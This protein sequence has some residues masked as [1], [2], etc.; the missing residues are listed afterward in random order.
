MKTVRHVLL[1]GDLA[2]TDHFHVGD[3]AMLECNL[4]ML[5]RLLPEAC[6]SLMSRDPL[7]SA[8]LYDAQAVPRLGFAEIS[9]D[10][11][12]ELQ[13][14]DCWLALVERQPGQLPEALQA[15]LQADL[16]VISGGGNLSSSWP[17]YILERLALVRLA[18]Q[19]GVPL[20]LLGQ[21]LG[22]QLSLVDRELVAEILGA[23]AWI[24]LREASSVALAL[25]LGAPL[26]RID[27]QLDDAMA[28]LPR[29]STLLE[30]AWPEP[31]SQG[32]LIALTLHPLFAG[33]ERDLWLDCVATELDKVVAELGARF[34][35]IPHVCDRQNGCDVGDRAIGLALAA[36]LQQPAAMRVLE[37]QGSGE[38]AWL[39]QQADL[40]VSSRYHPLVF[41]LARQRPCLG[42]PTD[43]YTLVKLQGALSHAG[44]EED[45]LIIRDKRW[46][47]LAQRIVA[48]CR[49]TG[50]APADRCW[51]SRLEAHGQGRE[52]RLG[53]W[54]AKQQQGL[55]LP[56]VASGNTELVLALARLL[57]EP[58][59]ARLALAREAEWRDAVEHW[60]ASAQT[61]EAY[62]LDLVATLQR[63]TSERAGL[64]E[65][66]ESSTR[67]AELAEQYAQNLET[68][69]QAEA[70]LVGSYAL[71]RET[72]ER[73]GLLEALE[74]S[75][76]RAELAE[77]YAQSLE[78]A[79]QT[80]AAQYA[81][82][83]QLERNAR[84]AAN[85]S[86]IR[87]RRLMRRLSRGPR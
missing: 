28:L 75:T 25:G 33:A 58:G 32:P 15:L 8:G 52:Q 16:L 42:L 30:S 39:T 24:G 7:M 12:V 84:A 11:Q 78:T 77:Q 71:Q 27:Y 45:L 40:V 9:A 19:R 1:I 80:E 44:R 22:P 67:R 34:L 73:A 13:Q 47:G 6:F 72:S 5:R 10:R 38:T 51:S 66:L 17:G 56:T 54:L 63:E 20:L 49:S 59:Q 83:L 26:A 2:G 31:L 62:V 55:P 3:E 36:R 68:A 41:A 86:L 14:I 61:A 37:V 70:E 23:A 50:V 74:S 46:D 43:H 35:F 76:R 69:R 87:L 21:T 60:Q 48:G 57:D 65:A 64:L 79:R 81:H 29:P 85:P 4:Q 53:D 18:R 82:H